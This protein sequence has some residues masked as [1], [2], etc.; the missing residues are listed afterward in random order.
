LDL[1]R[2]CRAGV[3]WVCLSSMALL[4]LPH[5]SRGDDAEAEKRV[6]ERDAQA[7]GWLLQQGIQVL[8]QPTQPIAPAVPLQQ[9]QQRQLQIAQRAKQ[10]EQVF[11]PMLTSELEL[12]RHTCGGLSPEARR[13]IQAA[14]R[15]A[16]AEAAQGFATRQQT[17]RLQGD[18]YHPRDPIQRGLRIALEALATPDQFAVYSREIE[19]REMRRATAAR[20][21]ILTRVDRQLNL[22][23]SQRQSIEAALEKQWQTAWMREL[24]ARTDMR[25]NNYP[26]APDTAAEAIV[27]HLDPEQAA[28][29]EIWCRTA[30][31]RLMG[32]NINV[33]FHM[34]GLTRADDWWG[35]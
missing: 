18:D 25:I 27:P 13:A 17:G 35:K 29:W 16:V 23:A 9:Q 34:Q 8:A 5:L 7:L 10:M 24:D 32:Q 4:Y 12:I 14:G 20:V 3:F 26:P 28:A 1:N 31:S 19:R 2:S 11:Q 21:S 30:G 33:N 15:K 6:A 22:S